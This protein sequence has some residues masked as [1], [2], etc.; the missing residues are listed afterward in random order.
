M[1]GLG[2]EVRTEVVEMEPEFTVWV[3]TFDVLP[4]KFVPDP[5]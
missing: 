3:T 5:P 1:D 4:V 2:D